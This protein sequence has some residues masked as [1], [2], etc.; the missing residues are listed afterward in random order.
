[1]REIEM[2]K[3]CVGRKKKRKVKQ[4]KQNSDLA[5]TAGVEVAK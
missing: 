4:N 5:V 3:R 1:M 2:P